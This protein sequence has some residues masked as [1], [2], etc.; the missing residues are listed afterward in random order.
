MTVEAHTSVRPWRAIDR[1]PSRKIR[2]GS[3]EVGEA[4]DAFE[5]GF[6]LCHEAGGKDRQRGVRA[7]GNLDFTFEAI[8]AADEEAVHLCPSLS[9]LGPNLGVTGY[10]GGR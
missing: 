2:E 1:R 4:R 8:A 5:N 3:V 7:A 10:V 9:H 6:A